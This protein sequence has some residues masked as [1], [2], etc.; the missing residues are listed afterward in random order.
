[1]ALNHQIVP[2][3]SE[4]KGL[5]PCVLMLHQATGNMNTFLPEAQ[6]LS[7]LGFTC[8]LLEAPYSKKRNAISPRGLMNP[9]NEKKIWDQTC[10]E[11]EEVSQLLLRLHGAGAM[12]FVGLN[13]GGSVGT[14]WMLKRKKPLRRA[15]V[16][17]AI[18][19]LTSFW[20]YSSH[21]VAQSARAQVGILFSDFQ[22]AMQPLDLTVTLPKITETQILVQIGSND[23][24]ISEESSRKLRTAIG[25]RPN[26][27][28]TQENDDHSMMAAETVENRVRFL[29][30]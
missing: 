23:D 22:L 25:D 11:L 18:P 29:T 26:V 24:W 17:G 28:I 3:Q 27:R 21:P 20:L 5:R 7:L 12:S 4:F 19:D 10:N 8:A 6:R 14:Y 15:I 13:L 9:D 30:E 1:M 16:T 2:A